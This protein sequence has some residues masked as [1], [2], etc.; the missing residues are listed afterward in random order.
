MTLTMNDLKSYPEGEEMAIFL[1]PPWGGVSYWELEK[2]SIDMMYPSFR[3]IVRTC[4]K[5]FSENLIIFLP[6]N[7]NIVELT[8]ALS[9]LWSS[10]LG[11]KEVR[12][13]IETITYN[14]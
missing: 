12:I 3:D 5:N 14:E 10:V 2:Y 7:T 4:L 6:R 9:V 11:K 8:N 13:E 1:S